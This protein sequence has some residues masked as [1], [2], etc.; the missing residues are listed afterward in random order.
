[1]IFYCVI[2]DQYRNSIK[3]I[4]KYRAHMLNIS[5]LLISKNVTVEVF[6]EFKMSLN[7]LPAKSL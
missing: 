4:H 1:M 2:L 6:L 3:N 7:Y 5:V